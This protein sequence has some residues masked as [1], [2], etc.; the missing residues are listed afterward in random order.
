MAD[1]VPVTRISG[2]VSLYITE[3]AGRRFYLFGDIHFSESMG[4]EG[5]CDSMTEDKNDIILK[6]KDCMNLDAA[7]HTWLLYNNDKGIKTDLFF[8]HPRIL[9]IYVPRRT[10]ETREQLAKVGWL[11]EIK[12]LAQPCFERQ[13][14]MKR[15]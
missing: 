14:D 5:T 6:G 10:I 2:P 15:G 4:C 1:I 13:F 11:G 9:G 7:L 8:E 3:Y 12:Y